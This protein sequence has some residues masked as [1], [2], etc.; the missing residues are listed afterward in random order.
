MQ[1]LDIDRDYLVDTLLAL[2]AIPSPSGYTDNIVHRVGEELE[3]LG[4]GFELTRRGA[5]RATLPG[6]ETAA[7]RAIVAHV[8]TIGAMVRGLLPNGRL[9]VAQVGTWPARFAEQ[10]R[11]TIFTRRGTR[12][13]TVLPLKASGHVYNEGVDQQMASW[14]NL[15]VRVEER[16]RDADGLRALGFDIGDYVAFDPNPE[17]SESGFVLAR[18]LDDKAGVASLLAA[19]RAVVEARLELPVECHLLFTIF[20]E[21][22][23]GASAVLHE[24]VAEMVGIDNATP[25]PGQSSSEE[26]VT[27]AMMDSTGPFDWHLTQKLIHLAEQHEIPLCRDVFRYYRSDA[28]SALDAGNDI[29]T[30]LLCFGVDASHGPERTHIDSLVGLAR[31]LS[32]YMQSEITVPRDRTQLGPMEGFPEQPS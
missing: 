8:D 24:N 15:E 16:V 11:V 10:G 26:M 12:R 9:A 27:I 31:L 6:R 29:R 5:I 25:A 30:A 13:G 17:V 4:I 22:G 18:H 19:A 23:S 20:E 7:D 21:V 28:A 14:D 32:V 3:A 1:G 2:L